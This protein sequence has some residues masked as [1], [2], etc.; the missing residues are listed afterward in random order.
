ML[1]SSPLFE[2]FYA[3]ADV[4]WWSTIAISC[5]FLLAC[6]LLPREIAPI[7]S[8]PWTFQWRRNLDLDFQSVTYAAYHTNALSRGSH[9]TLGLEA[10]AWFTLIASIHWSLNLAL[11]VGTGMA[12]ISVSRATL[13]DVFNDYLDPSHHAWRCAQHDSAPGLR[14]AITGMV[15]HGLWCV[16]HLRTCSRGY[17]TTH[18]DKR[19]PVRSSPMR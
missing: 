8:M 17:P 1:F 3:T 16:S 7:Q 9:L 6:H 14:L 4:L 10:V 18:C 12:G 13:C 2:H 5:L 19:R 15:S 11:I